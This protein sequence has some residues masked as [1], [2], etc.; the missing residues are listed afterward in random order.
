VNDIP[1]LSKIKEKKMTLTNEK[2]EVAAMICELAQLNP[3]LIESKSLE[4]IVEVDENIPEYLIGDKFLIKQILINILSNA[5]KYTESGSITLEVCTVDTVN[6]NIV[7]LI[8]SVKDTGRGMTEE[9]LTS[10][11]EAYKGFHE[12]D[13]APITGTGPGMPIVKELLKLMD[14]EIDVTSQVDNGTTVTIL[15]PQQIYSSEKAAHCISDYE[16]CKLEA[17]L[18]AVLKTMLRIRSVLHN[19]SINRHTDSIG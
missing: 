12:N 17:E 1:D 19:L 7:D 18:S 9:Q 2:Y 15:V 4:F 16:A 10:V 11:F 5:A 8:I 14:G 6:P 3:A 13:S